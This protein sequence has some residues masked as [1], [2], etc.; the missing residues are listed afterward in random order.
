[1]K[2]INSWNKIIREHKFYLK[3]VKLN[4]Q[5]LTGK[6]TNLIVKTAIYVYKRVRGEDQDD[7]RE[8]TDF[9]NKSIGS[10]KVFNK[11]TSFE[12]LS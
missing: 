9:K 2:I 10:S 8:E 5:W 11:I 1:M 7:L 12:N 4:F 6:I 3:A